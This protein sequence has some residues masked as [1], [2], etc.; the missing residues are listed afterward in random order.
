MEGAGGG[1][2]VIEGTR[3]ATSHLKASILNAPGKRG[4]IK[5]YP[6]LTK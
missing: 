2:G 4:F 5:E 6:T 3:F 1:G